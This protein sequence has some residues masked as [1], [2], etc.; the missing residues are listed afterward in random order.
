MKER[1]LRDLI[2]NVKTGRLSRR[3]FVQRMIAEIRSRM[4]EEAFMTHWQT[5][6]DNHPLPILLSE[7][8]Q[9]L[10]RQLV[11]D[12]IQA[13]TWSEGK[14]LLEAHL[15]LLQ[16]ETDMLLQ[17]LTTRQ[18]Q[19]SAR[20]TIEEHRLLL[21][22]CREK[23]IDAAFAEIQEAQSPEA[24]FAADLDHLCNE[25]VATLRTGNTEQHEALA[26]RIERML[27]DDLP[28]EGAQNFLVVLPAWLREED[29]QRLVEGLQSPFREAY[30]R[31]VALVEQ[32]EAQNADE[33]DALTIEQLPSVVSSVMSQ[34]TPEQRQQLIAA[35]AEAQRQLPSESAPLG[36]FFE[37]LAAALRGETPEV[38]QLV[39]PFTQLWQEFQERLRVPSDESSQQME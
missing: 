24:A 37:C 10:L 28:I 32:E 18:E 4:D 19:D 36:R 38:T 30:T 26:S 25:V 2:A 27:K 14:R 11:I 31:M 17:E 34:G 6:A 1:E 9:Q 33:D 8:A 16:P 7:D 39:S 3:A 5:L 22:Q 23:G 12:F 15:E 29:T 35:L 20:K 13:P 21:A